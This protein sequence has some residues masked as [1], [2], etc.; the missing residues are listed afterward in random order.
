MG[1]RM[2][3]YEHFKKYDEWSKQKPSSPPAP[4]GDKP[5]SGLAKILDSLKGTG[6]KS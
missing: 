6:R 5:K 3:N 4:S 2:P 1:E